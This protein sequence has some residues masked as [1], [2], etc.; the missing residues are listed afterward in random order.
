MTNKGEVWLQKANELLAAAGTPSGEQIVPFAVSMFSS[1]YGPES[2]Q[3]KSLN[4]RFEECTQ[5]KNTW[6]SPAELQGAAAH[7]AIQSAVTE[8]ENG[9]I[10]SLR[11]QVTGE[12]LSE[13]VAIGREKLSETTEASKNV[14]AVLI[15]AAFEDLIR[16]MGAEI[17]GVSGRPPLNEV[18]NALKSAEILKGGEIGTAQSYLKFRNDSLHADWAMVQASQ[19]QSCI[20]FIEVLLA[21]HFS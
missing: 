2:V 3:L 1:L 18:L 12:V 9:L 6:L 19:V 5:N 20:G 11:A 17:A 7:R 4:K 16:R 10:A 21:K 8:I 13:L 15:A 14:S